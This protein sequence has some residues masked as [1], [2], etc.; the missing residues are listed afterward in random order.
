MT[1]FIEFPPSSNNEDNSKFYNGFSIDR[2]RVG[3]V[4]ILESLIEMEDSNPS[5]PLFI[6]FE[7]HVFF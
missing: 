3:F 6:F 7:S 5:C 1:G 4:G 2:A